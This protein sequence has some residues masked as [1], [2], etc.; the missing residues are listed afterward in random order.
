MPGNIPAEAMN[1]LSRT[2]AV[3]VVM[4]APGLLGYLGDEYFGTTFLTAIGF[5]FG[6]IVGIA[7]LLAQAKLSE[8]HRRQRAREAAGDDRPGGA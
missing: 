2:L 4:L 1:A 8:A 7:V 3:G 6:L 5:I